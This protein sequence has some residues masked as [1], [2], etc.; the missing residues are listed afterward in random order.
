[1]PRFI[2]ALTPRVAAAGATPHWLQAILGELY[3]LG[4]FLVLA[5]FGWSFNANP[6]RQGILISLGAWLIVRAFMPTAKVA[7]EAA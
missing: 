6:L 2:P 4:A 5:I 7:A 1:V 3:F